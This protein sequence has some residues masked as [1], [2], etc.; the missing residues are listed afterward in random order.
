MLTGSSM[1]LLQ[2]IVDCLHREFTV[3]DLGEL[4]FFLGISVKCN[5][6]SF[7]LSQQRYAKDILEHA[8]GPIA[9]QRLHPSIPKASC[10]R[11]TVTRLKMPSPTEAWPELS[12]I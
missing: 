1:K 8:D 5:A 12:S 10:L 11:L 7:Y 4:S 2:E 6:S 3:K 9:S